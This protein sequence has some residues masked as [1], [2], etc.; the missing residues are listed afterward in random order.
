MQP[1]V[2]N[3]TF[4]PDGAF[5]AMLDCNNARGYYAFAGV[6]LSFHGLEQTERGCDPP[7]QHEN[8]VVAALIGDGYAIAFPSSSEMHLS[9]PHKVI[10]RRL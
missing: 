10:L 4:R 6:V 8:L 9:G 1:K 7:L 3:V 2:V 5:R